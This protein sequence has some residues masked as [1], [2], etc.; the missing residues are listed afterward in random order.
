MAHYVQPLQRLL[1]NQS[2]SPIFVAPRCAASAHHA[3]SPLITVLARYKHVV[4]GIYSS[5]CV[6]SRSV[7]GRIIV[8][9]CV[10]DTGSPRIGYRQDLASF[11]LDYRDPN[12]AYEI[13]AV[14][15]WQVLNRTRVVSDQLH[16]FRRLGLLSP[17]DTSRI[18][19]DGAHLAGHVN[20]LLTE[21]LLGM[22][23]P[24]LLSVQSG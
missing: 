11:I 1:K 24:P 8:C 9:V 6:H 12:Y 5:L 16:T 17:A 18:T 22:L 13:A 14:L 23:L 21:Q 19:F 4:V 20:D 7:C 3:R 15:G 10:P 2:K